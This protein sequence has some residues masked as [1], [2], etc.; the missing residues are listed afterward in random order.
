MRPKGT[1]RSNCHPSKRHVEFANYRKYSCSRATSAASSDWETAFT[2]TTWSRRL[3]LRLKPKPPLSQPSTCSKTSAPTSQSITCATTILS[4]PLSCASQTQLLPI[5]LD[6][7]LRSSGRNTK[8]IYWRASRNSEQLCTTGSS[9]RTRKTFAQMRV[10]YL[11]NMRAKWRRKRPSKRCRDE[12]TTSDRYNSSMCPENCTIR[13]IRRTSLPLPS[14]K[15]RT[16][17][18]TSADHLSSYHLQQ[19]IT[20][21]PAATYHI[22]ASSNL[23]HRCQQQPIRLVPC[24]L[25]IIVP[26]YCTNLYDIDNQA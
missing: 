19:P 18:D 26:S 21:V 12:S 11:S 9:R 16:R 23:S 22:G 3:K 5:W 7:W 2:A 15:P 24:S 4:P 13:I 1:W 14:R 8:K 17:S 25:Y 10:T 6:N 20:S